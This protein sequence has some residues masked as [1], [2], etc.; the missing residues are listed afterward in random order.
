MGHQVSGLY[1]DGPV[2]GTTPGQAHR[3]ATHCAAVAVDQDWAPGELAT[4]LQI[5]GLKP[6]PPAPEKPRSHHA[7]RRTS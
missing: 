6:S 1:V 7:R 4:V 2:D 3:A 5:L